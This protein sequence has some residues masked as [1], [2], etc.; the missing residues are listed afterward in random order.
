MSE[1]QIGAKDLVQSPHIYLQAAGSTGED[2][3]TPGVHLRWDFL[4]KL[5]DAH[6]PKGNLASQVPYATNQ[7]FNKANDFVKIYSVP[8][9]KPYSIK[10][11]IS[12]L[13]LDN[14]HITNNYFIA[15]H[16]VNMQNITGE[17]I[18]HTVQFRF[19][20]YEFSLASQASTNSDEILINY[21]GIIE[22]EV[23]NQPCFAATIKIQLADSSTG[24]DGVL[25]SETVSYP[26]VESEIDANTGNEK[27]N[28]F[29]SCR[30]TFSFSPDVENLSSRPIVENT[31]FLEPENA[32]EFKLIAENIKYI[33]FD[34]QESFPV[35]IKLETYHDFIT[36]TGNNQDLTWQSLGDFS[37]SI[38]DS[39]VQNR[40][41]NT[42][43]NI[44][45]HWPRFNQSE[46]YPD[47]FK[48]RTENYWNKW[49]TTQN[50]T[51]SL[52]EGVEK[53]LTRSTLSGNL[54]A[55]EIIQT[56]EDA[57]DVANY[58]IN[59]L[60]LLKFVAYD[61]HI[62]RMLGLAHIHAESVAGNM[63]GKSYIYLMKYETQAQLASE[64][65]SFVQHFFMTLPTTKED[66]RTPEIPVL[67]PVEYG[68]K[69]SGPSP[70]MLTDENGYLPDGKARYIRLFRENN[71]YIHEEL[72]E[73]YNPEDNFCYSSKTD[74][75]FLG[76]EYKEDGGNW[77]LP[78]LNHDKNTI[79]LEITGGDPIT[80]YEVIPLL[81]R[82]DSADNLKEIFTHRET[83]SGIHTYAIY[84]INWFSR[85]SPLSNEQSTDETIFP[86]KYNL[87]PPS[88]FT[89]QLIMQE[90]VP[91]LTT[92]LEQQLLDGIATDDETLVR[93]TFSWN[94]VHNIAHQSDTAQLLFRPTMP[95]N[96][97][98]KIE[99]VISLN[100]SEVLVDIVSYTSESTTQVIRPVV[101]EGVNIENFI[102]GV[103]VSGD[104]KYLINAISVV[105]PNERIQITLQK[106]KELNSYTNSQDEYVSVYEY[107]IPDVGALCMSIENLA[108][109]TSWNYKLNREIQLKQFTTIFDNDG[110]VFSGGAQLH[111]ETI[112][113]EEGNIQILN[114]GGV[115]EKASI[116]E[117]EDVDE[118]GNVISDSHSGIYDI[119]FNN[120]YSLPAPNDA[121]VEWYNGTV[122][123][124]IEGKDE[125]KVLKVLEINNGYVVAGGTTLKLVAYDPYFSDEDGVLT[126]SIET[127]NDILVNFHPGYKT[128]IYAEV[129]NGFIAEN[130]LPVSGLGPR[131]T[132]M[133]IKSIDS[134]ILAES[135]I[136]TPV[137]LVSYKEVVPMPPSEPIGAEFATRPDF[138]GKSTYTVDC[139]VVSITGSD[140]TR[141]SSSIIFYRANERSI[142]D[143]LYSTETVK[144]IYNQLEALTSEEAVYLPNL[145]KG[146]IKILYDFNN[147]EFKPDIADGTEFPLTFRF[148]APDN[149]DYYIPQQDTS[150]SKV[151]PFDGSISITNS[152]LKQAI[153][154]AF[155][156]LTKTPIL[157][158][159]VNE[160]YQTSGRPPKT[161][162]NNGKSLVGTSEY[163][164]YPMAVYI[165]NGTKTT[166]RFTDYSL[167]GSSKNIYFYYAME[168]SPTFKF[169]TPSPVTGPIRLVN[170]FAPEAPG[171]KKITSQLANSVTGDVT[172]VNFE[173]NEYLPSE[174]ISRFRIYRALSFDD[175]KNIRTMTLAKTIS[176]GEN[177][178][179][180]FSNLDFPPYGD[181]LFYRLVAV[182][183]IKN[184]QDIEEEIPSKPSELLL[185]SVVDV[186]NPEA[187]EITYISGDIIG[188]Y[189]QSVKL[190]WTK[191]AHN[192]T[193]YLYKMTSSGN[194]KLLET[195][196]TN[197]K[198]IFYNMGNLE[199][200]DEDGNTLYHRFKVTVENASGLLNLE[201][202]TLTI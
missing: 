176:V 151:Y 40:L 86:V 87:L 132:F 131:Q 36:G 8:Y 163:D 44:D 97:R 159:D 98:G 194:W 23:I 84:G 73:F 195:I 43:F 143:V 45:D 133:G 27:N 122:R 178:S 57:S 50:G 78:V 69:I 11:D 120:N 29:V 142:L 173:V 63:D 171:I 75:V 181:T 4:N 141:L 124:N 128:Y 48:V 16:E 72:R 113:D 191:T 80:N 109:E 31:A 13:S 126:D 41:D 168:M 164:P 19:D 32:A 67:R 119:I 2:G 152:I 37:L 76:L 104:N 20:K 39:I 185:A 147:N 15:E 154:S 91:V 196:K 81:N 21:K 148:P 35:E 96:I 140:D 5:G 49:L 155:T 136:S 59:Y 101:P 169:S 117:R 165:E 157:Y 129:G 177:L 28:L 89:A 17:N 174:N 92:E 65:P 60:D 85:Y 30:K 162:D 127:G 121:S 153:L 123:I 74:P 201:E 180:D 9:T 54:A 103:F 33:R 111:T 146:L 172:A 79:D 53:Y 68:L 182:R 7:A 106:E 175:A 56:E 115:F 138:Y 202:K 183:V 6:L 197:D 139:D 25:R 110:S 200:T 112:T 24:N 14:M 3:S 55:T 18:T 12:D 70:I 42:D 52:K 61:F 187:P 188:G 47:A 166:I 125:K 107:I 158:R 149:T 102:G 189:L 83:F 88:D 82:A 66:S 184:E 58:E 51:Q 186:F 193:Y 38:D 161:T 90:D 22:V 62:A 156:P 64:A 34:Y 95:A 150:L 105:I 93:I 108:K 145:W 199:K 100:S 118:H 10:I 170:S 94:H 144:N 160:G 116:T 167:D 198:N 134:T 135:K 26:D 130:I 179:D 190:K 192:A 71:D 137:T 46:I 99:S 114:C 1:F 77:Q